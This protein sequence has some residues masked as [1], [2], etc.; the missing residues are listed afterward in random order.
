MP[1]CWPPSRSTC[2]A[3]GI[4]ENGH[5]A[6]NDPPVADFDDPRDVKVVT[7]DGG[8]RRQQVDE[9]HFATDGDVPEQAVT[10]TI[11]ALLRATAG[12]GRRARGP[13]GGAGP[14]PPWRVR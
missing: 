14:A 6:F 7:L 5:L 12:A 10:V 8:C 2:A 1:T 11:P 9:G 4:G 3:S 13:Q